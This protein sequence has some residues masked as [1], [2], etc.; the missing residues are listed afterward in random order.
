MLQ[1]FL[2]VLTAAVFSASIFAAGGESALAEVKLRIGHVT[3]IKAIAGRGSTKFKETAEQLSNGEIKV[4]I[5][6]NGQL[7]GELEMVSQVRLGTLD[8]AMVGSGLAAN[9]EPTF[10]I[11]ELPFIWKSRESAW[12]VLSGPIGQK[13]LGLMEPKGIKGLG[14]GVWGF[15][16]FLTNGFAIEG[17][18]SMKGRKMRIVENP[19]YVQTIKA[20]GGNPV[21]MAW[22]EVYT[23]LQ[24][25]AIDGVETN[26]HGMGD[27]KLYEVAS[28]L[29]LTNHIFTATVYL[30]NMDRFAGL[31]NKHQEI[32]LKAAKAAG[33][34]MRD[35]AQKAN[36]NA[37]AKMQKSGIKVIKPDRAAFVAKAQKVHDRFSVLVGPQLLKEVKAAQ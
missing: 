27:A 35:G 20:F 18:D 1:R 4:T 31:S 34:T 28:D 14:W 6:P 33:E 5:F 10:S 15:R 24:Q 32:I 19:L 30:M 9:I 8:I 12:E 2:F 13:I 16:G 22:P 7:G 3:T 25:K 36:E 21:P 26:Y 11:T 37:I 17:P 23:G 29:S